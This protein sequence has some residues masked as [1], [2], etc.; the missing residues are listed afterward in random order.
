MSSANA[1][2]RPVSFDACHQF[3]SIA[4][5]FDLFLEQCS[6]KALLN[7]TMVCRRWKDTIEFSTLLQEHM[8]L[9]PVEETEGVDYKLNPLISSYFAPVL[10]LSSSEENTL[11]EGARF[12]AGNLC[13]PED[14]K[15]MSWARGTSMHAPTRRAFAHPEASWRNMLISQPPICRLDWWHNW[16]HDRSVV[17]S[18]GSWLASRV[19]RRDGEAANGWGHQDLHG[20]YITLGVSGLPAVVMVLT[21][22]ASGLQY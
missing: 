16:V 12:E 4:E 17:G 6:V 21:R 18:V 13:T 7:C 5:L 14:L 10:G 1:E 22:R 2:S 9:S 11:S 15:S 20:Q 8:F 19:S 3:F